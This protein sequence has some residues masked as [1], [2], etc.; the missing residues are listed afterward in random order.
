M[1][2]QE[3]KTD[4]VAQSNVD[5]DLYIGVEYDGEGNA[6]EDAD[7]LTDLIS[8]ACEWWTKLTYCRYNPKVEL[9]LTIGTDK[10]S[11]R[12]TA[13]VSERVFDARTVTI[14]DVILLRRDGRDYGLW[15]FSDFQRDYPTWKTD[16]DG[17]PFLACQVGTD[18]WLYKAPE[19][20]YSGKNFVDGFTLPDV[21]TSADETNQLPVPEE[22]HS[23]IIRL[24]AAFGSLP[25]VS[26]ESAWQRMAANEAWWKEH[27]ER[28][29]RENLNI[30]LGRQ[31][32][33]SR[34]DWLR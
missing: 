33:G 13:I 17:K 11:L 4:L 30:F 18:L 34:A 22:D 1:T 9:T 8:R 20:I 12:D 29:K 7:G 23:A 27:A 19:A 28:R 6:I 25:S 31:P 16:A 26:S 2:L 10:Y 32:R 5:L 15:N 14:N 3:A 21:L 24:A